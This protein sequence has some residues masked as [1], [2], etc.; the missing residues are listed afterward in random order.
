MML[1]VGEKEAGICGRCRWVID[2]VEW[3]EILFFVWRG[4]VFRGWDRRFVL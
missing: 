4:L 3:E 2:V 1:V